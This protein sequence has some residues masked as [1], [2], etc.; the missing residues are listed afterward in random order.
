MRK[1]KLL[2]IIPEAPEPEQ[3]KDKVIGVSSVTYA[4]GQDILTID[5]F[6][7]GRLRGRYFADKKTHNAYVDGKWYTCK[8]K[9]IARLCKDMTPL[10]SGYC[11]FGDEMKWA[12]TEDKERANHFL[13]DYS[14]ESWEDRMASKKRQTARERK[15]EQIDAMM[16]EIP[17]VPEG[18][19][20]WLRE[21]VFS[22]NYLYIR[23]GQ[24]RTFYSCTACGQRSWKKIKWKHGETTT[25]PKC[26]KEVK[27]W[28]RKR[29]RQEKIP[30]VLIQQFGD[31]WVERQFEAICT[32][33]DG[34]KKE[35]D[36]YENVRAII[37][38]GK[39][40]GKVWYGLNS[41]ADEFE[42]DFWDKNTC[43]K[44]FRSS[45]LYPGNLDT[46]LEYGKLQESGLKEIAMK[47]QKLNVNKFITTFHQRP[48]MEYLAKAGLTK[49]VDDIVNQYGWYGDPENICDHAR[50]LKD[51]LYLNGNRVNRIKQ[52]NGGIKTL[53]WLQ[54]EE[55]MEETEKKIKISTEALEYLERREIGV[56]TCKDILDEL[57]SVNRMVNYIKKQ[58]VRPDDF[59]RTWRDYLRM[60]AAEGM[61]TTDDIVRFPRDLR[62]RHDQLVET[63]TNR[64]NQEKYE[65]LNRD[66]LKHLHETKKYFWEN[67][68]YMIIPA[69]KCEELVK[70]GQ[71][72]HHCVG[73]ST[74]YMEKMAAGNTWILFLRKKE[75]L[76]KPYYTIEISMKDD[77]IIQWYSEF[78][79]KPDKET[80][81]KVLDKFKNSI[82][83]SQKQVRIQ[84]QMAATA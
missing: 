34:E 47:G 31:K 8:L 42:Q 29:E 36:L 26:G 63:R 73:S 15:I 45:L 69:G 76:E 20:T 14:V 2:Q 25:C 17:T 54:Y 41:D 7:E 48:W 59:V 44:H 57:G 5:L 84:M 50:S 53:E 67:D 35:I 18:M 4:D 23:R 80:I 81:I 10:K 19:E 74:T 65:K 32:W 43:S 6:Y 83:K 39:T 70:E 12:S 37:E 3:I 60:A 24:Q 72:L 9:N 56:D 66:I 68:Q 78:D 64:T 30:V 33:K 40:W 61:D 51:A 71:A 27:V 16:A 38:K 11:Y 58:K 82:K 28:S 62:A 22:V 75:M 55:L 49:L 46:V 13:D 77:S 21:K 79:R 52:L 1:S